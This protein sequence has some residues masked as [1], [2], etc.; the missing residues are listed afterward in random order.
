MP[1][2]AYDNEP[3]IRVDLHI[4]TCFSV[5]GTSTS[6]EVITAVLRR[7]LSAIAITD[8]G[9]IE[10]AQAVQRAAPFPVIVGEE[11]S[12]TNGEVIGLFLSEQVPEGLTP[13]DTVDRIH[14]QGGVVYVPHPFDVMRRSAIAEDALWS[15]L[16]QIDVVEVLNARV[17]WPPH[18]DRARSFA[19]EHR[20]LSGAGSDAHTPQEIGQAYVEMPPFEDRQSFLHG[21]ASGSIGGSLSWPHVHL[22]STLRRAQKPKYCK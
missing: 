12:T 4:H 13:R 5:D 3:R 7:G 21:L 9:T 19:E 20:L 17:L 2:T 8:H 6:E 11:I 15:I 22:F 14:A 1:S 18:N 16:D 10:G